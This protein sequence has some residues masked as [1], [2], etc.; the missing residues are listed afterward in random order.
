MLGGKVKTILDG[1]DC[2]VGLESTIV[3]LTQRISVILRPGVIT[4]QKISSVLGENVIDYCD[5]HVSESPAVPGQMKQHYCTHTPLFLFANGC[6]ELDAPFGEKFA[7]LL[8]KKPD[9]SINYG[10][11]EGDVF[12]LSDVGEHSE[13][14][15]NLFAMLHNLDGGEY[16]AILCE[17]PIRSGIGIAIDDRL[18]RAAAKFAK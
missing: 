8:N 9:P 17:R 4:A 6:R 2:S 7:V 10:V 12:W 5:H 18:Q 1:G 11:G 14:A 15:K 13:I 3:D 16:D